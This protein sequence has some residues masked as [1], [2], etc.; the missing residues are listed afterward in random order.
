MKEYDDKVRNKLEGEFKQK[1]QN[2]RVI[3]KQLHDFK[4]SHIKRVKNEMLEGELMKR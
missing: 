2:A 1:E 3:K 4:M